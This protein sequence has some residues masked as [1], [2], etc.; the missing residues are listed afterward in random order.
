ML[1]LCW[2][3]KGRSGNAFLGTVVGDPHDKKEHSYRDETYVTPIE[4]SL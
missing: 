3:S 4:G 1:Y 2:I